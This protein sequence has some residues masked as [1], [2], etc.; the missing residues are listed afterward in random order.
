MMMSYLR[1]SLEFIGPTSWSGVSVI[2]CV[3]QGERE[4]PYFL[5][6]GS[7]EAMPRMTLTI[8]IKSIK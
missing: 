2:T 1:Y 4:N 6:E 3:I 5:T 7:A 8:K